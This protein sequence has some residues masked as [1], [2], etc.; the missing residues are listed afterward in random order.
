[1]STVDIATESTPMATT[2]EDYGIE[3]GVPTTTE[4]TTNKESEE[5]PD[6]KPTINHKNYL[7][8]IAYIANITLVYGIGN[9]RHA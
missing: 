4:S 6:N 8:L 2:E 3:E 7:N 1:M 5:T 9:A